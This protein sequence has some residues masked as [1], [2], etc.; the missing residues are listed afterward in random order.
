LVASRVRVRTPYRDPVPS[1]A[2]VHVWWART[3]RLTEAHHD[4]LDQIE[5]GRWARFQHRDDR[6]RF[7]LGSV[8]LRSLV[9]E[10][11]GTVAAQVV[12][13]RTC[14][15][16][17]EQHGPVTTP[18]RDWRC[19]LTHSGAFAL[20]AA[21]A[22]SD[23]SMVGVDLETRCPPDWTALATGLLAPGEPGPADEAGFLTTWV[24]KEAVLKATGE[25]LSRPMSTVRLAGSATG[26]PRLL[27]DSP[28]LRLVDLDVGPLRAA[29][30]G[31]A[32]AAALAVGAEQV[33]VRWE[34]ARI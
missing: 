13:D 5:R 2:E 3:D 23:A 21:V 24:R 20:A 8:L 16:C 7:V 22:A 18:G 19:S 29:G 27:G 32:T 28:A 25:G 11:D 12:L 30:A 6:D 14:P 34:P 31:D 17:G 10:L 9:A 26:R 15:R 1:A 33:L 4:L